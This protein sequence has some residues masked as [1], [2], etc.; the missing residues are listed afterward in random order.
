MVKAGLWQRGIPLRVYDPSSVKLASTGN[1]D[2]KKPDMVKAACTR[3][4]ALSAEL[5]ALLQENENA[6][7]NIA[8][9]ALIAAL[10]REE[11]KVRA[12]RVPLDTLPERLRRVFLRVTKAAPEALT[13]RPFLERKGIDQP[14]PVFASGRVAR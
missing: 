6:A 3:F 11:L 1:G 13:T 4:A 7:G 12:G 14:Q 2:A 5:P 9:A 8:D 10:L